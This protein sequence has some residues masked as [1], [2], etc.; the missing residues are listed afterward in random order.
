MA[1]TKSR[2]KSKVA[3]PVEPTVG[4]E[5]AA[6]AA[7]VAEDAAAV[8]AT[9]AAAEQTGELLL[10]QCS[11]LRLRINWFSTSSKIGDEMAMAMLKD[12]EAEKSMVSLS[13]KFLTGKHDALEAVRQAK[14][15]LTSYVQSMTVPLLAIR[16]SEDTEAGMQKDA[17]VRLIQKKDME[18]FDAK[19]QYLRGLLMTCVERLQR[20]LPEI[21]A[22]DRKRLGRLFD[23]NDYPKNIAEMV[24]VSVSYEPIGVDLDWETMCPEIYRREAANARLKFA[25]VAENAAQEFAT[26]FVQYVAQVTEQLGSRVRLNPIENSTWEDVRDAEV[27]TI[28]DH[29][30]D[31]SIPAGHVMVKVRKKKAA[32]VKGRSEDVYLTNEPISKTKYQTELRPYET[33]EKKKLFGST[34]ENLKQQMER[35]LNVGD[36]LGPYRHV[37][38][39]SVDR[40]KLLLTKAS[41]NMD[42]EKIADELRSGDYLRNEMREAL[43]SVA[44]EI[45][46]TVGD[47]RKVRRRISAKLIGKV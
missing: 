21:I 15:A 20:A 41:D 14:A 3:P 23:E 13:K 1:A 12:T 32:G 46:A 9:V 43:S 31:P 10:K 35:F 18:D 42:S 29:A 36:M 2:R 26:Q 4:E 8:T 44:D 34:I 39:E 38:Q 27:L 22:E 11:R 19:V 5:I 40:V 37:I 47:S 6:A 45:Q 25:A 17:G 24:S 28:E 16:N 33:T 7:E 30:K